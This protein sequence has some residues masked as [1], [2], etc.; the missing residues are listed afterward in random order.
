MS[1]PARATIADVIVG[2]QT[3]VR[4]PGRARIRLAPSITGRT[5]V[6]DAYAASPLRLLMP[7]NSGHAAW[8][9]LSSFGG[10]LVDGDRYGVDLTVEA[11]ASAL[12]A[13]Q[14]S[15]KVYRSASGTSHELD[16]RVVGDGRLILLP[17]PVVCFAGARYRQRQTIDLSSDGGLIVVDYLSSGRHAAGERWAFDSYTAMLS[18]RIDGRRVVHDVTR[19]DSSDAPIG[20][21]MGRFNV[22]AF[23]L[24]LGPPVRQ[25]AAQLIERSRTRRVERRAPVLWTASEVGDGCLVRIA[26]ASF[27]PAAQAVRDTLAFVPDLLGDDPW[28]RKW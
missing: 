20:D 7:R 13:T 21:R 24:M 15:T 23:V 10:G 8:I 16:A 19:L 22:V 26:A 28:A 12:L 2:D 6:T 14:A 18:V 25:Y 5:T 4:A 1:A 3:I 9:Y 27:E 11:G 17:D